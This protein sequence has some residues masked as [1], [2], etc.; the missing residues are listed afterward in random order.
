V[1]DGDRSGPPITTRDGLCPKA[2]FGS[3]AVLSPWSLNPASFLIR[4]FGSVTTGP[5]FPTEKLFAVRPELTRR[6]HVA[7]Q[8]LTADAE[9]DAQVADIGTWLTH[10][11]LGKT[12]FSGRHLEWSATVAAPSARGRSMN[13]NVPRIRERVAFA[14][15][16][17]ICTLQLL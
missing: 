13:R 12:Q 15:Q 16:R 5:P 17:R 10:G 9:L 8:R 1:P 4:T 2:R 3:T 7:I 14:D 6:V 11:G